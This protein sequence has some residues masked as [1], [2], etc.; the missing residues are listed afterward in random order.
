MTDPPLAVLRKD[1]LSSLQAYLCSTKDCDECL[2]DFSPT[3]LSAWFKKG[4]QGVRKKKRLVTSP[5]DWLKEPVAVMDTGVVHD[6]IHALHLVC[7]NFLLKAE[8]NSWFITEGRWCRA[9]ECLY[10]RCLRPFKA[11]R[12]FA[13]Y[14]E[15]FHANLHRLQVQ[16][17]KGATLGNGCFIRHMNVYANFLE[18]P[19][20]VVTNLSRSFKL[21]A[22]KFKIFVVFHVKYEG[23]S[24]LL[25]ACYIGA[26]IGGFKVD[27]A[28]FLK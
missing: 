18:L 16:R 21:Y 24:M 3:L 27:L 19:P 17:V 8:C 28:N 2:P 14:I 13:G 6:E 11:H 20:Q 26:E 4:V 23:L 1:G 15:S 7:Y 25:M 10:Y 22:V 5:P 9:R 12:L